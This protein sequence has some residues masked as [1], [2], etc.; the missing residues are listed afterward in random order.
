MKRVVHLKRQVG[1][2]RERGQSLVEFAIS[3]VILLVMLAGAVDA[4][5]VLYTYLSM[6]D[7]AQE[8]A[9]YA[10]MDPKNT[11]AIVTRARESSTLMRS[12]GNSITVTVNPT[13]VGALCAGQN[14][15]VDNGITVIISYPRFPLTMPFIGQLVGSGDQTIPIHVEV[16]DSIIIP[17]CQ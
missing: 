16:T 6:R 17:K 11:S 8:G 15:G 14:S 5:R 1:R 3:L 2:N 4:G 9:L 7:A 13:V 10:S 12:L